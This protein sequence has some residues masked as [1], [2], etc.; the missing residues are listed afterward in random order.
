LCEQACRVVVDEGRLR[1]AW[2]GRLDAPTGRVDP[3]AIWGHDEGYVEQSRIALDRTKQSIGPTG[4]ALRERRMVVNNDFRTSLTGLP[5]RDEALKRGYLSSA[6]FPVILGDRVW[7]TL[8]VHASMPNL[9]DDAR[10]NMLTELASELAAVLTGLVEP[11]TAD[12]ES[13]QLP[14]A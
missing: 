5:W 12:P 4:T 2:I 14:P 1:M 3:I 8:N 10:V 11:E 9:F 13:E 6:A 7:G